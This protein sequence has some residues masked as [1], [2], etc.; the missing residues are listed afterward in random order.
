MI[1]GSAAFLFLVLLSSLIQAQ[2][3]QAG[4][5]YDRKGKR[6]GGYIF[7][8][9]TYYKDPHILFK[10]SLNELEPE[11]IPAGKLTGFTMGS[12]TFAILNLF[13]AEGVVE[14]YITVATG[15]AKV[16]E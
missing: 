7:H 16:L 9:I 8:P 3:F 2:D 11:K 13:K 6:V 5:Y 15:V 14:A 10:A 1:K 4:R 12:D